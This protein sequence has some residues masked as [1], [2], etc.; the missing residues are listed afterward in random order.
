[1]NHPRTIRTLGFSLALAL[2]TPALVFAERAPTNDNKAGSPLAE[3]VENGD[4]ITTSGNGENTP[5]SG[6]AGKDAIPDPLAAQARG[7]TA[8]PDTRSDSMKQD[9]SED[10]GLVNSRYDTTDSSSGDETSMADSS[11]DY[12]STDD[13]SLADDSM[14]D[15][16][17]DSSSMAD[18]TVT[19]N[20][21]SSIADSTSTDA[22]MDDSMKSEAKPMRETNVNS[23]ASTN[24]S[25][26][27]VDTMADAGI[28]R[29]VKTDLAS[30]SGV[31]VKTRNGVIT[32]T[33][34]VASLDEKMRIARAAAIVSGARQ[35]DVSD[36][37]IA[38]NAAV[39]ASDEEQ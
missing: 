18:T 30:T 26:A 33:G 22:A 7:K 13:S 25:E 34:E 8:S 4:L 17:T 15:D 31:E 12:D 24:A 21:D 16:S 11:T 3:Q 37:D 35:V 36:L 29:Q 10:D 5:A 23:M 20:S 39:A 19:P 1:M 14:R 32:L 28:T 2:A 38:G 9:S 6:D 27:T